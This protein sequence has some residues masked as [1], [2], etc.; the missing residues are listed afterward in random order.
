MRYNIEIK[1]IRYDE[2][3]VVTGS[4]ITT[5]GTITGSTIMITGNTSN[6][7]IERYSSDFNITGN[8]IISGR[9][10]VT[11]EQ[12]KNVVKST[13]TNKI[14]NRS[15]EAEFLYLG[16]DLLK[17]SDVIKIPLGLEYNVVVK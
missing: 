12:V 7:E 10:Y 1:L 4:T 3:L 11:C 16:N 8:T 2:S 17:D 15:V 6:L 13:L 14:M 9:T 5:G